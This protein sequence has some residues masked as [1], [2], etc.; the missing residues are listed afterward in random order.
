M[1][2][3][4]ATPTIAV[5][6]RR[7]LLLEERGRAFAGDLDLREALDVGLGHGRGSRSSGGGLVAGLLRLLGGERSGECENRQD[8]STRA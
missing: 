1:A 4:G 8:D 2:A 7:E 5:G 3:G 6:K